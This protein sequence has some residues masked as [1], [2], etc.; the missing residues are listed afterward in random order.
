MIGTQ[1]LHLS[2]QFTGQ[3]DARHCIRRREKEQEWSSLLHSCNCMEEIEQTHT[4]IIKLGGFHHLGSLISA[5]ALSDWGCMDYACSI[6]QQMDDP[7][8]F[9][10]NTMLRGHVR[11]GDPQAAILL[12]A[13]MQDRDIQPD[14]FTYAPLLKGCSH[15]S[16]LGEG[17]QI[18][19]HVLKNGFGSNIFVQNSLINMYGKCGEIKSS[20]TV[21]DRMDQ[22]SIAS[23]SALISC[24][25]R[26]GLWWESLSLLGNMTSGGWRPEETTLVSALSSSSHL[27]VLDFGRCIH[28]FLLRNVSGLNIIVQT[29]LV[30][31]YVKSGCLEK[32]LSVFHQMPRKNQVS[33][34][35]MITGLAF[36]GQAEEA[37]R[38]FSDMLKQGLVPDETIYVGVLTA[39][40]QAG[41]VE[42]GHKYFRR[43]TFEH[44][45][46]PTVQHYGCM[47]DLMGHAGMLAE[48]YE[49]IKTMPIEPNDVVWRC[50]LNAGKVYQNF[51]IMEIASRN[52]FQIQPHKASDYLLL[53]N[54][55]AQ[56][57][58]WEDVAKIRKK[59]GDKG[60][61]QV[62]GYCLVKVGKK[63]H[64]FVSQDKSHPHTIAVYGMIHQMEWQLK[65]EGY[66]A[67][68][69]Q[70]VLN[71]DEEEKRQHLRGHSQKLALAFSLMHTEQGSIIRIIRSIRMCS[72]CHTY[73]R[74]ISKIFHKTIVVREQ[75]RFHQFKGGTC[76][77]EIH[78]E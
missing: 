15:L 61:K 26:L 70:V 2:H 63:V 50:L 39:C 3:E 67:D 34:S 78:V 28:G 66:S 54:M 40:S 35:V 56:D 75:N 65:F 47:V 32:G 6:F 4:Q 29:S 27:G 20:S 68:T 1:I 43:M 57:H 52:L 69:S 45:V 55:Y 77:C 49:L 8:A 19:G 60:V 48:A 37:F 21:F 72:D 38:V 62:P 73:T 44:K 31:M 51:E 58:K 42:E 13:E 53:S 14:N 41:L 5:C 23:W 10:F 22:R 33:Y 24:H 12:Y 30:D 25:T 76:S 59:M 11:G 71:S 18:H 74:F 9:T 16:A 64:K 17:M 7:D 36:Y 46:I